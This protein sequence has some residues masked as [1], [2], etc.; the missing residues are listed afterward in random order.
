M[1]RHYPAMGR[2]LSQ[3][4]TQLHEK[5]IRAWMIRLLEDEPMELVIVGSMTDAEAVR[6]KLGL[7]NSAL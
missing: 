2:V 6:R 1:T 3:K 4:G 7:Q 5:T